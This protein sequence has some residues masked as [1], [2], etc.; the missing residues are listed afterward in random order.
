MGPP[1]VPAYGCLSFRPSN[2]SLVGREVT[3]AS[4]ACTPLRA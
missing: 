2:P 4:D 1:T 3:S